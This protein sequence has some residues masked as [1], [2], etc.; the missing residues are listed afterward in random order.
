MT[1][2]LLHN[3]AYFTRLSFMLKAN[4]QPYKKIG[5]VFSWLNVV[6][7]W[8]SF[9]FKVNFQ[10]QKLSESFHFFFI[11]QLQCHC[12]SGHCRSSHSQNSHCRSSHGSVLIVFKYVQLALID[13]MCHSIRSIFRVLGMY[14]FAQDLKKCYWASYCPR[15]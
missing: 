12:W 14:N 7:N 10:C 6:K 13:N 11:E 15:G 9:T 4:N 3:F 8:K 1:Q 2:H 5:L